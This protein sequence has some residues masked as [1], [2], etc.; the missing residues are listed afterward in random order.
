MRYRITP[1]LF[2]G[3]SLLFHHSVVTTGFAKAFSRNLYFGTKTLARPA[4]LALFS[5]ASGAS[6]ERKTA[7]AAKTTPVGEP[8][9][10]SM[11]T[12]GTGYLNAKDAAALDEELMSTPGFSLE[13]LM[14]LAG[15]AV[16]EAVYHGI[17]QPEGQREK[18][19]IL[20]VCGPGN[21]GGDGLVAARHLYFWGNYDCVVVYPRR[22]KKHHFV[23]L[24][25][26]CE[27]VGIDILDEMPP[28]DAIASYDAIVDAIFGF[29]FKGEPRAPFGAILHQLK[30]AQE[31]DN[32][33]QVLSVDV[34]S[35][36]NVDEGDVANTGFVPDMLIS[37]TAPKL[38]TKKFEGRHFIGGRF[39]P[40]GVAEKYNVRMPPYEGVSQV[41]EVTLKHIEGESQTPKKEST[42]TTTTS[43]DS[44]RKEYEAY[45]TEK[46][47]AIDEA[48]TLSPSGSNENDDNENN[49]ASE[50]TWEEQYQAY[51]IGKEARLAQEDAMKKEAYR[52][53]SN[54]F[55]VGDP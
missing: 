31:S 46:E 33:S 51:C 22:S 28:G 27:D 55:E 47:L 13:Q 52:K 39:L 6:F 14:E 26:Q 4:T 24:V 15:L 11:T 35:G 20:V 29:S 49:E 18:R 23:N 21:N 10:A 5:V 50:E 45:L 41:M 44:W 40:P 25:K 17:P 54:E 7:T 32:P 48:D 37:L 43:D 1:L 42:T 12:T 36:W 34:P 2:C 8:S 53:E 38:C 9:P 3:R 16:A 30:A 19:K